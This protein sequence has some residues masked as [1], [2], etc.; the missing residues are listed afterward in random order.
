MPLATFQEHSKNAV[1]IAYHKSGELRNYI[2]IPESATLSG[3]D[4][5]IGLKPEKQ[6][7]LIHGYYASVSYMDAQ[8]GILLN[9]LEKLGILNNTIIVLWGDHGWHLGDHDL[10]EKHTTFEQANRSPLIIAG[11]GLKSGASSSLTEHVDIFPTI[12]DLAGVAIP[13]N[14]AGKSLVPVMKNKT[15]Q[16]KEYA[17]SQYYRSLSAAEA[18]KL[19]Y[20]ERKLWGY[21]MRTDQF[22]YVLWMN[23]FTSAQPFDPK[24]V[25]ASELYDLAND[26]LETINVVDD[27]KY[28]QTTKL[29]YGKMIEYFKSQETQL[30]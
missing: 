5:R 23:D 12:C 24:K 30:K 25:Y 1:E 27:K 7:E 29:L 9:T 13:S 26:P 6:K 15:A 14:L 11:P 17:M 22:R 21:S 19:G 20:S 16:V 10:W 8:V 2:D 4:L 18:K 3:S 28:A